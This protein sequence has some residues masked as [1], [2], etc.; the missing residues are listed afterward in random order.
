MEKVK[1]AMRSIRQLEQ[2]LDDLDA[3]VEITSRVDALEVRWE[4]IIRVRESV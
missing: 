4:Q 2:S 1:R 3:R